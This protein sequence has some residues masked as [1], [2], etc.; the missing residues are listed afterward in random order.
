MAE[1]HEKASLG[2]VEGLEETLNCGHHPDDADLDW[3]SRTALHI[4]SS[5]GYRLCV[6][7]LINRGANINI[8]RYD[9]AT[10][11][12]CACEMGNVDIVIILLNHGANPLAR[13]R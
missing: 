3:G 4:S 1:L 10:P 13:D 9:D 5:G 12:H 8:T 11:L 7:L 6:H 2:D